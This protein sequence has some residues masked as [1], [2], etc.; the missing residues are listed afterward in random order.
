MAT[1]P[2][3]VRITAKWNV[4]GGITTHVVAEHR[5]KG[6]TPA[7]RVELP[8]QAAASAAF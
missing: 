1:R 6:W 4:R 8:G 7:A 3:F 5:K 2:R